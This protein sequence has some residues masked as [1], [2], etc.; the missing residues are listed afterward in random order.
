LCI[1]SNSITARLE[2]SEKGL[3]CI[4]SELGHLYSILQYYTIIY[5]LAQT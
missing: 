1:I 3:L 5:E 4:Y 2:G